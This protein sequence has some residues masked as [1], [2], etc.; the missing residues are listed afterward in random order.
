[1]LEFVGVAVSLFA[2]LVGLDGEMGSS[3]ERGGFS[4]HDGRQISKLAQHAK[5]KIAFVSKLS[6]KA[7]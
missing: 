4:M 7:A 6:Q 5:K 1:V 3:Y 2:E